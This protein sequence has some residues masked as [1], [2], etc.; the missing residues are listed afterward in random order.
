MRNAN[1]QQLHC[2]DYIY[3]GGILRAEYTTQLL[4]EKVDDEA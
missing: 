4:R 3:I 1:I 2:L